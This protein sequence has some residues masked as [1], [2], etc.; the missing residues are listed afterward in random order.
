MIKY[1]KHRRKYELYFWQILLIIGEWWSVLL[2]PVSWS[3]SPQYL[4]FQQTK[5]MATH[6]PVSD[7]FVHKTTT[8][9]QYRPPVGLTN[10]TPRVNK[11][12]TAEMLKLGLI[13]DPSHKILKSGW[14]WDRNGVKIH[15]EITAEITAPGSLVCFFLKCLEPIFIPSLVDTRPLVWVAIVTPWI[16]EN[17]KIYFLL[18]I[19][20]RIYLD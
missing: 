2:D 5:Q 11:C 8:L 7:L 18:A 9:S 13:L 19:A 6:G 15:R 17:K 16:I 14:Q 10:G 1:A 12:L 4:D 3:S 20:S